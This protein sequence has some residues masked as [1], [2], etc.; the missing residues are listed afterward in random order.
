ME[1]IRLL[2]V[3]DISESFETI[4][5][6]LQHADDVELLGHVEDASEAIAV[7]KQL[8]PDIVVMDYDMPGI[9]GAEATRIINRDNEKIQ[10]IM[11]SVVNDPNDIRT[12]MRA[13]A[14]DYLL[15]PLGDGEL[16]ETVRWLIRERRDYA[17]MQ[18]FVDK[19][20]KAYDSLFY[21]DKPVPDRVVS[22]IEQQYAESP[23]D[24]QLVE[25]LAVAYARN[26][27]WEK[28]LPLVNILAQQT[29]LFT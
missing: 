13:G 6:M 19:M 11:L 7:C 21:D 1:L 17:R 23:H 15:K 4:T 26:R 14:R 29:N 3:T 2:V 24:M 28:L 8:Q 5:Q 18:S 16:L 25:T 22:M 27:N 10:I 9:D 20:R 12:A